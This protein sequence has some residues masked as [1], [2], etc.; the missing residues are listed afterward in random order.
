MSDY[1]VGRSQD[2]AKLYQC[3]R[4]SE[5]IWCLDRGMAWERNTPPLCDR[6][7]HNRYSGDYTQTFEIKINRAWDGHLT[8][9][10]ISYESVWALSPSSRF[11][12]R[13]R[14]THWEAA[15][16]PW[17]GARTPAAT[18]QPRIQFW[19]PLLW[20][21]PAST[22]AGIQSELVQGRSVSLPHYFY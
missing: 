8:C 5:G 12:S 9:A 11:N 6:I 10:C 3:L 1:A 14:R 19:A 18:M 15:D 16:R 22:A 21:G 7:N 2:E 17:I 13:F 4:S 20:S